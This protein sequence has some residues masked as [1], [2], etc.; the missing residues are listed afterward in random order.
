[1][2]IIRNIIKNEYGGES[3]IIVMKKS[4]NKSQVKDV[5]ECIKH[6]DLKPV[7][8]HGTERTVIAIIGDERKLNKDTMAAFP[9]VEEVHM[10]LKPYK[11]VSKEAK[12]SPSK[13]RVGDLVIGAKK[14]V[15]MA[16]PC[17]VESYDQLLKIA[18]AVKK[19]GAKVLRGGA[20]KPRTGPYNFQGLAEK[21][22]KILAK[23]KKETGLKII[24]EVMDQRDVPLVSKYADILQIGTR[25]MQNY[26]LL[27]EVG[28]SHKPVLLKRGLTATYDELLLAAE[29]IMSQGNREVILCERGIRTFSKYTRNTLD[30]VAIPALKELTHLPIVV[31]PS[32]STGKRSLVAA[33]SKAAIAAGADGLLIEVHTHPEKSFVDADQTISTRQFADLMKDLKIISKVNNRTI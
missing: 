12:K 7:P 31:D 4:A 17:A 9:G 13:V 14:T 3:M 16:G 2:K 23:V 33:A 25:N 11:L 15:I 1:M 6:F 22:L 30:I 20:F 26:P 32:H 19:A 24:T 18:K 5:I 21:G 27:R 29:Y 28:K 10:I 8:L